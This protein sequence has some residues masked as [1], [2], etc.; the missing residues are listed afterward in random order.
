MIEPAVKWIQRLLCV[1]VSCSFVACTGVPKGLTPVGGFDLDKYTGKWY[2]IVRLD[3]SF[4]RGLT[5]VTAEYTRTDAGG[6]LVVNRGF[7]S[8]SEEWKMIEGRASFTGSDLVGSL[9]VSFFGPFYGGYHIIALDREGYSYAM[10]SGATRSY[11]WILARSPQLDPAI[12]N[13]LVAKAG[14]LGF[15]TDRLIFVD[16]TPVPE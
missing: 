8:R 14:R 16:Q 6:V 10:I 5:R 15:K 7:D 1:A 13:D 4:E 12:L 11:L 9:K 3:H 2:E